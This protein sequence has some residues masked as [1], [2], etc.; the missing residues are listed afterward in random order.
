M[1]LDYTNGKQIEG[2]SIH[3]NSFLYALQSTTKLNILEL[4]DNF[5]LV[6]T[7]INDPTFHRLF[8]FK[9]VLHYAI[10]HMTNSRI[11]LLRHVLHYKL[12]VE[13]LILIPV[14]F[15]TITSLR[16]LFET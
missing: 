1:L 12:T 11:T 16:R 4:K 10:L 6:N 9:I 14:I 15:W 3:K 7:F 5:S 8:H 13:K 2:E